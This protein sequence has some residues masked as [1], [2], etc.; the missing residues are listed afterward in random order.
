MR[1]K[2]M[3]APGRRGLC[4]FFAVCPSGCFFAPLVFAGKNTRQAPPANSRS[5]GRAHPL[6]Y[7]SFGGAATTRRVWMYSTTL[8]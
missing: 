1:Y 5:L 8:C 6:F 3:R 7:N 2:K 4:G